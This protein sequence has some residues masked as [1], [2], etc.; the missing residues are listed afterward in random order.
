MPQVR[1]R[2]L[3]FYYQTTGRGEPIL[4]IH[5]L[6]SS[7]LDWSPQVEFFAPHYQVV[8][9]DLRGHG[10]S[11]KPTGP[12]TMSLFAA[13]TAELIRTL[14]IGPTHVVGLSLG[15]MVA[16]QLAVDTPE[17]VRSLVI[18]NSVPEI[19]IRSRAVR[20]ALVQRSLIVRLLGMRALGWVLGRR[21]FPKDSQHQLRRAFVERWARN[22]R[23]AYLAAL[24]AL[25][26][27]S[28]T[29]RLSAI[30][31]PTLVIGA[32]QDYTPVAVK[33]S[34]VTALGSAELVVIEDSR[35]MTPLDQPDAFNRAVLRFLKE[36]V[37][38]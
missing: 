27:W 24:K 32:D 23:G 30:D 7:T 33:Q 18:V 25:A 29:G 4:F 26:G 3:D 14:G 22:Q 11:A 17:L 13:D 36:Q 38:R 12:Y 1:V 31:C 10:R 28:V 20:R 9:F 16:F 5:G 19:D 35:H 6:G 37:A 34:Y 21:L 15:G 2:D 8:T